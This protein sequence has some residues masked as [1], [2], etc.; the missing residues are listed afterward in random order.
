MHAVIAGQIE[1]TEAAGRVLTPAEPQLVSSISQ[2]GK[3]GSGEIF[4]I[5]FKHSAIE[6]RSHLRTPTRVRRSS[7]TCEIYSIADICKAIAR[8]IKKVLS[9]QEKVDYIKE[10]KSMKDLGSEFHKNV[11]QYIAD[12]EILSDSIYFIDMELCDI[13]LDEYMNGTQ[14]ISGIHGLPAW[15]KEDPD[16]FL[17]VAIVQQ[18]LSG[19]DFMHKKQMVHRDLDPKNGEP[20]QF[21]WKIDV[22]IIFGYTGV[23]ETRRLWF[24]LAWNHQRP[25]LYGNGKRQKWLS[26]GGNDANRGDRKINFQSKN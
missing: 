1:P 24:D 13:N 6:K 14:N 3:G 20:R 26:C 2:I 8:K 15:N 16:L 18:L 7:I 11:I 25:A 21:E 12:G 19:L 17:I 5:C 22:S 10:V 9:P 23:V 4:K